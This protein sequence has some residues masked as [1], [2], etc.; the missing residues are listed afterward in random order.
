MRKI[1]LLA[2]LA[3]VA[4]ACEAPNPYE[5]TPTANSKRVAIF[6]DSVTYAAT[7]YGRAEN[8]KLTNRF[9]IS[10][11]GVNAA[12]TAD[13]QGNYVYVG[14]DK[15][16]IV[17]MAVGNNDASRSTGGGFTHDD[18]RRVDAALK[19]MANVP[20]ILWVNTRSEISAEHPK[21]NYLLNLRMEGPGKRLLDWDTHSDGHDDWVEWNN[22]MDPL[23]IHLTP[24]GYDAYSKWLSAEIV[25]GC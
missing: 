1:L 12:K 2:A 6:G 13:F 16:S 18:V 10:W 21:W 9:L 8:N 7:P 3:V 19:A 4:A 11:N 20:C 25:K 24:A 17:V 5:G 14:V 23:H 22:P 15:P